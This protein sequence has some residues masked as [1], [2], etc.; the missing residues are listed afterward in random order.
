MATLCMYT[1]ASAVGYGGYLTMNN[2]ETQQF[3]LDT[4]LMGSS[5]TSLD[6]GKNDQLL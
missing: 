3:A 4:V 1:D 2:V 5:L 6:L